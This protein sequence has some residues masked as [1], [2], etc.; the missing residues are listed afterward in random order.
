MTAVDH[1]TDRVGSVWDHS[2]QRVVLMA[3]TMHHYSWSM[4][5]LLMSPSIR[6]RLMAECCSFRGVP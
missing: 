6:Y 1:K 5:R 2:Q 3:D 4:M